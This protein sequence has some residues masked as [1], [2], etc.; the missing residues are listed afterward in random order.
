MSK[1]RAKQFAMGIAALAGATGM[2]FGQ[3]VVANAAEDG[4]LTC[5][6]QYGW[7]EIR[8]TGG[9]SLLPPGS[10]LESV[11]YDATGT[12]RQIARTTSGQSK[13]G[14]G[15]WHADG[16]ILH[17]ARPYCSPAH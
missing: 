7:L 17:S 3:G 14:G 8:V 6:V 2:V 13:A 15:Y 1:R 12:F 10:Q 16:N 11:L 4:T 5:G 9:G